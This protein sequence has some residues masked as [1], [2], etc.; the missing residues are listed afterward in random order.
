MKQIDVFIDEKCV[1]NTNVE[2]SNISPEYLD[3]RITIRGRTRLKDGYDIEKNRLIIR[4][5]IL[6]DDDFILFRAA[7]FTIQNL[8]SIEDDFEIDCH[9]GFCNSIDS[10]EK[11]TKIRIFPVLYAR[12]PMDCMI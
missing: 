9:F 5:E 1:D 7:D 11:V 12:E 2:L 8:S 10:L 4:A 3:D 6:G